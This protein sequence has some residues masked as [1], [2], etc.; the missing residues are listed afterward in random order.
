MKRS[1]TYV[2]AIGSVTVGLLLVAGLDVAQAQNCQRDEDRQI[3]VSGLSDG[4]D[5]G[6]AVVTDGTCVIIGAPSDSAGGRAYVFEQSSSGAW[7]LVDTLAASDASA[8][9]FF[10]F[11]VGVDGDVAIVGAYGDG[12]AAEDFTG[13]AYVFRRSGSSWTQ[14]T[15]LVA[16]DTSAGASFGRSVAIYGEVVVVGAPG[17]RAAYVYRYNG[18]AWIAERKL[19]ADDDEA[20]NLFGRAVAMHDDVIVVGALGVAAAYVYRYNGTSWEAEAKLEVPSGD[21]VARYGVA[22]ATSGEL[23]VVGADGETAETGASG[24]AYVYRFA[25]NTWTREARLFAL[26][27]TGKPWNQFGTSVGVSNEIVV[28]G[29]DLDDGVSERVG[30]AYVFRYSGAS[31]IESVKLRASDRAAG[32]RL[33][34]AVGV[35]DETVILGSIG[36]GTG[37]QAYVYVDFPD[38]NGNGTIDSCDI[39]LGI[40]LDC[41]TNGVPD[42]CDIAFGQS[43]DLN[44]NA[45]PDECENGVAPEPQC[46]LLACGAGSL[47]ML[48]A[49]FLGLAALRIRRR[50]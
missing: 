21:T 23:I 2:T 19:G 15:K 43:A 41:N 35:Y 22:V 34:G 8:G 3:T 40:S 25:N 4:D 49:T 12:E 17:E 6:G 31:W 37:G 14:E 20:L 29:A 1:Q 18:S 44:A 30:A 33:G 16:A 7:S 32:N 27:A 5:F 45:I 48:P 46:G 50:R 36:A 47:G 26:D 10:G 39:D 13:A 42:E 9:D 11:A 28:V 24:S 38:C